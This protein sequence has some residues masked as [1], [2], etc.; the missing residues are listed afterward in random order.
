[1]KTHFVSEGCITDEI[2]QDLFD[3][4]WL[5]SDGEIGRAHVPTRRSSDLLYKREPRTISIYENSLCECR[6]Y[7]RRN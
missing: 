5:P 4:G 6:M 7:Y 1:M 3:L 2:R